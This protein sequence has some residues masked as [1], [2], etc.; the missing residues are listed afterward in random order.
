[1]KKL[2][3]LFLAILICFSSAVCFA[4]NVVLTDEAPDMTADISK[5]LGK[6]G[7]F[8]IIDTDTTIT[9]NADLWSFSVSLCEDMWSPETVYDY[10]HHPYSDKCIYSYEKGTIRTMYYEKEGDGEYERDSECIKNGSVLQF[11]EPGTY[12]IF[13]MRAISVDDIN[14]QRYS[15]SG[16]LSVIV[17]PGANYVEK[18]LTPAEK[19]FAQSVDP[20]L[21]TISKI[22]DFDYNDELYESVAA[23][24]NQATISVATD[25]EKLIIAKM[26]K[27][28]FGWEPAYFVLGDENTAYDNNILLPQKAGSMLKLEEKGLY[29]IESQFNGNTTRTYL[30]ITEEN[31]KYTNS[32]VMVDGKEVQFEAYNINGNNY[33]KL[34]DIAKVL[35]GTS[36]QFEVTWDQELQSISL[37]SNTP[38]TEVGGE[39]APGDCKSKI[40]EWGT[41]NI[42]MNHFTNFPLEIKPY[43]INGNNYFKLRDLGELFD[44][45]VSWDGANN[46]VLIDSETGYSAE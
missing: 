4:E 43:M 38:Y 5:V 26:K 22:V 11:R 7:D 45:G 46:C 3:A 40:A 41:G 23:C 39:L 19:E 28:D 1:M 18:M 9:F 25:L 34:R 15:A 21:F 29:L 14:A 44:F 32:K 24:I 42:F 37:L 17:K 30:D 35:S 36:K 6:D 16:S 2:L 31:A 13:V 10:E 8:Y 20:G 33:F 12:S 27:T